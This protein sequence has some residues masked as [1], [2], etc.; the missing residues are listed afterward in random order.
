VTRRTKPRINII[1]TPE[2]ADL[3]RQLAASRGLAFSVL[4][5][6]LIREEA[7]REARRAQR[8]ASLAPTERED[9]D[10]G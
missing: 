9:A 3:G 1:L 5:D 2:A 6:Q 8:E 4:L 10:G 7:R